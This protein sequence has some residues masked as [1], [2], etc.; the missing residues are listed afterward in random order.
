MVSSEWRMVES[1]VP[2]IRYSLFATRP[3]DR[4]YLDHIRHEMLEQV[5]D[6][7]LQRRG[8]RRA[9]G[10]GALHVEIDDAVLETA[11]GDVPAVI[12]D[13]RPHPGLDQ[14]L[15]GVH[16]LGIGLVEELPFLVGGLVAA[17]AAVGHQRRA[18]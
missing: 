14:V 11:E 7:V 13:R 9:A 1:L 17:R 12:G 5:L 18:G 4:P 16:G 2:A 8:R 6:A 10:A 3:L 15:D